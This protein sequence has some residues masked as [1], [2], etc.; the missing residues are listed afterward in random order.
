MAQRSVLVMDISNSRG[1][2]MY[3]SLKS[4]KWHFKVDGEQLIIKSGNKKAGIFNLAPLIEGKAAN[5]DKWQ[6]VSKTH[7]KAG[8]KDSNTCLHFALKYG[9]PC[10]WM[11][12]EQKQFEKLTYFPQTKTTGEAWQTYVSDEHDRL[13]DINLDAEVLISSAYADM[14]VDGEDG[15]GM[16]DPGDMPPTWIWNI[17]V[18]ALSFKTD[19]G[20]LGL[21]VPGP[22]PVGVT[23]L[24][25]QDKQFSMA[26]QTLRPA[27]K[28][29]MMPRVYFIPDLSSAYDVLN[30]QQEISQKMGLMRKRSP[31]HPEWWTNP[32]YKLWDEMARLQKNQTSILDEKGK[33]KSVLTTKNVN[34]WLDTVAESTR[35]KGNINLFFDQTYFHNYGEKDV[36]P[37]LGGVEGFRKTIDKL[38]KKGTRVAL[39]MHQYKINSDVKFYREHPECFCKFK[40]PSFKIQHGVRVGKSDLVFIDWTHPMGREYMLSLIE[41]ILSSEKG[42]LNADWLAF[43]NIFA[44]D[45]RKFD[46]YDPDWGIGDLMRYKVQ[47]LAYQKAKEIKPDCLVRMQSAAEPCFQPYIDQLQLC[48][49]WNGQMTDCYRRGQIITRTV[50]DVILE[51]DAWFVTLT[52]AN[53]FYMSMLVWNVPE[54]EAVHHAIHPYM[55]YRELKEKDYRR[56][57]S[58]MQVYMNAPINITDRC[59]VTW[60]SDGRL[61]AW[62]KYTRGKLKGFYAAMALSRKCFVTYGKKQALIGSSETRR[63]LIPLP[64]KAK[65]IGMEKVSHDGKRTTWQYSIVKKA[66]NIYVDSRIEDCGCDPMYFRI[67][68]EIE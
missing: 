26:F 23:R 1:D 48:E 4:G 59:M 67:R 29:G 16:T 62:R 41:F 51:T 37:E 14:N 2:V 21:S 50:R 30:V 18:R 36:I 5:L 22:L 68:Y 49:H 19:A 34:K 10:Y 25:M 47:R 28:E 57:R 12:T 45:P 31:N 8:I 39:Y 58:G 40:D 15:A 38:R 20:W 55:Y 33:Q 65:V 43:N 52:K 24:K 60:H 35:L 63:A 46:F 53:E 11:E 44:P 54:T 64:P 66:K 61:E 17:P 7:F 42:C 9:Y 3:K 56:R 6:E 27:C 13:W 32:Y